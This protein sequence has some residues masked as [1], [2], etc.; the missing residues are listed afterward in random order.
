TRDSGAAVVNTALRVVLRGPVARV[1]SP[2][3]TAVGAWL[4]FALV[5]W[6]AARAGLFSLDD[7]LKKSVTKMAGA[8]LALTAVLWLAQAPVVELCR[9]LP[10]MRDESALAVLAVLG[11]I[12][13]GGLIAV[14]FGR[15][16]QGMLLRRRG[17]KIEVTPD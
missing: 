12:V 5:V 10:R 16:W 8:S 9:A 15:E 3:A 14:L 6:F 1:G 17:R 7:R 11:A 13:Y 2:R 4:N